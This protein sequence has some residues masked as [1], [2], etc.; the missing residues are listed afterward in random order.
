MR[1]EKNRR[2]F[3]HYVCQTGPSYIRKDTIPFD[4]CE[5]YPI[6]TGWEHAQTRKTWEEA[7]APFD[8]S[9]I[10]REDPFGVN[11]YADP[12]K[13][14][15]V[16]ASV[17]THDVSQNGYW[18]SGTPRDLGCTEYHSVTREGEVAHRKSETGRT[19]LRTFSHPTPRP[20]RSPSARAA[21]RSRVRHFAHEDSDLP[22]EKGSQIQKVHV[23][24]TTTK[25]TSLPSLHNKVSHRS[26]NDYWVP[27]GKEFKFARGTDFEDESGGLC[28]CMIHAS[29]DYDDRVYDDMWAEEEE[30]V[31]DEDN[32]EYDVID[33]KMAD[34]DGIVVVD[35][36][37]LPIVV[38]DLSAFVE[39]IRKIK[40]RK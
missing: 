11:D 19:R 1:K 30:E 13:K 28:R 9:A 17:H 12:D 14:L 7:M 20:A 39:N 3:H 32:K 33:R 21:L 6:R 38:E 34:S 31:D 36:S 37:S 8:N 29:E 22:V 4:S 35:R 24:Y 5:V 2:R 15:R 10:F 18:F 40:N 27:Y 23:H 25:L 26:W 16:S